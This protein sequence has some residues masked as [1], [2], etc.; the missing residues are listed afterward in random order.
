MLLHCRQVQEFVKRVSGKDINRSHGVAL[1]RTD[2]PKPLDHYLHF[3]QV[4]ALVE[5]LKGRDPNG[6][7]EWQSET[8]GGIIRFRSLTIVCSWWIASGPHLR[9]V[10]NVD[11]TGL[12]TF[13]GGT[14]IAAMTLSANDNIVPLGLLFTSSE[15]VDNV[16]PFLQHLRRLYPHQRFLVSDSGRAFEAAADRAGF[17]CHGGCSWH[18]RDK[19]ARSKVCYCALCVLCRS[20]L[21]VHWRP[22][23]IARFSGLAGARQ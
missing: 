2:I 4:P 1:A 6:L 21:A 11:G 10:L 9:E 16:T 15:T 8:V 3:Q 22:K 23:G 20:H 14:L 5:Y 13:I 12:E 19:N 17:A 7:Y 18:V